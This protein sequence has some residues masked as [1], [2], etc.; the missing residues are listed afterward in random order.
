[1]SHQVHVW[2]VHREEIILETLKVFCNLGLAIAWLELNSKRIEV[3]FVFPIESSEFYR[4]VMKTLFLLCEKEDLI[5]KNPPIGPLCP[6]DGGN[7]ELNNCLYIP[8]KFFE[9]RNVLP[10]SLT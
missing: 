3:G 8:D 4:K 7:I 1:M 2:V 9:L 5:Y 10:G 6:G